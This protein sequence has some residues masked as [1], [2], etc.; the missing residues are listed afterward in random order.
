MKILWI[1]PE[2]LELP[3]GYAEGI[4][5]PALIRLFVELLEEEPELPFPGEVIPNPDDLTRF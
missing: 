5:E 3:R 2:T 1:D 4:L